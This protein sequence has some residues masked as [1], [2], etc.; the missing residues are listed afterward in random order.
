MKVAG[1][2][3]VMF[4]C[5]VDNS[6]VISTANFCQVLLRMFSPVCANSRYTRTQFDVLCVFID[7]I[8]GPKGA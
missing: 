7:I 5:Q 6:K 8:L 1:K 3:A 4:F 2:P